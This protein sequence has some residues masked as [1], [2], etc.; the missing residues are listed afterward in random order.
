MNITFH[1]NDSRPTQAELLES[2]S[3][4]LPNRFL[5]LD[6]HSGDYSGY[7]DNNNRNG[8]VWVTETNELMAGADVRV[9]IRPETTQVEALRLLD[10][11]RE[12]VRVHFGPGPVCETL[13]PVEH[14][15]G[16]PSK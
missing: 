6:G 8:H 12:I 10:A 11:I 5:Q 9:L 4:H 15:T 7:F 14:L 16:G 2:Y 3:T 1:Q 13:A